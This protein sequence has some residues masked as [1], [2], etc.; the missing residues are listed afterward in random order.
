MVRASI[1]TYNISTLSLNIFP[2]ERWR[3]IGRQNLS[4][5][6][7]LLI[8]VIISVNCTALLHTPMFYPQAFCLF[9]D[10]LSKALRHQST[11]RLHQLLGDFLSHNNEH[12]EALD[13][14]SIAL[15]LVTDAHLVSLTASV[16]G[17]YLLPEW[18]LAMKYQD[19]VLN[20]QVS[21][22]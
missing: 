14:Y 8:C 3:G 7:A 19:M 12:Q 11:S 18:C 22:R 13:Q 1:L 9:Y 17:G 2:T 6:H 21:R 10:R 15:R 20:R 16:Q 4:F 5:R